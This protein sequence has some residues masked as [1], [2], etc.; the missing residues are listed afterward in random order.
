MGKILEVKDGQFTYK[1]L[2]EGRSAKRIKGFWTKEPGT[3][4]WIN[5]FS[6]YD[7]FLDI[8]S[9]IGQYSIYAAHR[10]AKVF[11]VEPH[12]ITAAALLQN[13]ELNHLENVILLTFPAHS[14]NATVDFNY[15]SLVSG[16]S[17][18]QVN[19]RTWKNDHPVKERKYAF[20][21]DSM[22]ENGLIESPAHAKIDVDGNEADIIDGAEYLLHGK[23]PP[24]SLLVEYNGGVR[25]EYVTG[26]LEKLGYKTEIQ[27]TASGQEKLDKGAL[28]EDVAH[29]RLYIRG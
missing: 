28:L 13:I 20:S 29:N 12:I 25:G 23:N 15:S 9:N 18:S 14:G 27:M 21:I 19:G 17:G 22:I 16:S 11:A 24:V 26:Y 8:G 10:C 2:D 1:F 5:S 7:T 6:K 3:I 4:K